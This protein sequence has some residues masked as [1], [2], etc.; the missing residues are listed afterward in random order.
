MLRPVAWAQLYY[1]VNGRSGAL[2]DLNTYAVYSFATLKLIRVFM[3]RSEAETYIKEK[4]LTK[5]VL[6]RWVW[7]NGEHTRGY[8]RME[9]TPDTVKRCKFS[10]TRKACNW[11]T[12][13][14]VI[15]TE[16]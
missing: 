6:V 2:N 15:A 9:Y 12:I 13:K 4:K 3:E 5:V 11:N 14:G 7:E 8:K 1:G 16:N 10:D